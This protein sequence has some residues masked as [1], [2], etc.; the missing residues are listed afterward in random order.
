MKKLIAILLALAMIFTMA[1]CGSKTEEPANDQNGQKQET[2]QEQE[3]EPEAE[4][5]KEAEAEPEPAEETADVN[6]YVLAGP[7]GIGAIN[8]WA[9]ADAGTAKNNYTVTMTGANDEI[10]A[11]L[12]NGDADIAAIATNLASVL[13]NKTQGGISVIAVN[14]LGVLYMLSPGEEVKSIADLSGHTIYSPGEGANPEYILRYVLSENG[15]DPDKDVDIHFVAQG[16]DLMSVWAEDPSAIIMA[17]QPVATSLLMQNQGSI[18]IFNMTDEWDAVSGDG[19]A[20]MMGCVVVRNEFL[21]QHPGAVKTFLEEYKASIEKATSDIGGTADLCES[22][23]IIPKAALAAKALPKCGLTYVDGSEMKAKLSGYLKVMFD[24]NPKSV[25]GN[26]P[27][28]DFYY[29]A[30]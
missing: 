20:L 1:A 27:G 29:S 4:P 30:Q 3:Q 15:L 6:L 10:V 16:S 19:S 2:E 21:E 11:A 23:G 17:P 25:G 7:T 9:A 26:L 8:L 22:Y 24:A 13:Y 14:T 12:S 18:E 28:D 5:E